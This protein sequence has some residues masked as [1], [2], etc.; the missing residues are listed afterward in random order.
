MPLKIAGFSLLEMLIAM[1]ISAV[2]MLSVGRFL[3]LLLAENADVLQRAQLRQE[4]QQMMA[5][6]EKSVRRAGYCHGECAREALKIS[7]NCLLLRW[8]ENSNGQWEG[9][10]HAES[11]Y[12]GYRLRQQQ[13]EMQRGVEQCQSAG[14]ER[15]SDPAF[16]TLEQFSVSQQ[17]RQV[18]IVLQGRA[19]R[20]LETVESWIEGENL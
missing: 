6:L 14:W 13:L 10:S 16:M 7:E 20:W 5:T 8:D 12:Y 1:A 9:V 3:P 17:G 11:D 19:G 18:R 4:L 15:L 2:I